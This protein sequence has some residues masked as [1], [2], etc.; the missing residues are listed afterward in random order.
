MAN[1]ERYEERYC[2]FI[3]VLGFR[4][5]V[6]GLRATVE[7]FELVKRALAKV[8][9]PV[10]EAAKYPNGAFKAQSISDAVAMSAPVGDQKML[11]LLAICSAIQ[12]LAIELLKEGYFIRGAITRGFLYHDDRMVFGD[13]LV[14][15]YELERAVVNFPR[16]MVTRDIVIEM[17]KEIDDASPDALTIGDLMRNIF[18]QCEDGPYQVN[19]LKNVAE[20]V[21]RIQHMNTNKRPEEQ[22]SLKEFETMRDMIQM[23]MDEAIDT[24]RHYEKVKWFANYWNRSHPFLQVGTPDATSALWMPAARN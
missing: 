16:V 10:T 5:L 12:E 3:D 11:G 13:A 20:E 19:I 15:A 6:V 14:R 2:A 1:E 18:V 21:A 17:Q 22:E 4:S 23:R 7:R 24:P 9:Q 8:Y